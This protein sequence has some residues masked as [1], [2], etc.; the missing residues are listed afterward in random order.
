MNGVTTGELAKRGG[1]NLESIRFYEREKLLPKPPRTASGYRMFDEN[2]VRRVRFIKRAQEL[3]FSLREIRE[4]LEL[5]FDPRTDC[6]DVRRKAE[7]KLT[8]IE[9]KIRDLQRMKRSLGRLTTA[10]PGR[11][12]ADT[13]PIL[14]SLDGEPGSAVRTARHL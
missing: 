6:A 12:A 10:C 1:V 13:C 9:Q 14:E 7:A 2:A 4:L 5:R 8:D 3:G 11:G